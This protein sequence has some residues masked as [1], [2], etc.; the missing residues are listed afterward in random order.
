MILMYKS[1]A[2]KVGLILMQK[3]RKKENGCIR[4]TD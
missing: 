2:L 4:K 3:R 1:V